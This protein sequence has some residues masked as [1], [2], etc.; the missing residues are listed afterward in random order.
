MKDCQKGY[1]LKVVDESYVKS[2]RMKIEGGWRFVDITYMISKHKCPPCLSRTEGEDACYDEKEYTSKN[3]ARTVFLWRTS[4]Q[5]L[6]A[7]ELTEGARRLD[8]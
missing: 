3:I 1:R 7:R 4:E 8:Y 2:E 6:H 5:T